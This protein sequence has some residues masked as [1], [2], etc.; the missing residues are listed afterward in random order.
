MQWTD[1]VTPLEALMLTEYVSAMCGNDNFGTT[2]WKSARK[3]L[4]NHSKTCGAYSWEYNVVV[5]PRVCRSSTRCLAQVL[6]K[7]GGPL[8]AVFEECEN[9][10]DGLQAENQPMSSCPCIGRTYPTC[11]SERLLTSS[12]LRTALPPLYPETH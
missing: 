7:A 9:R 11:I 3:C 4:H 1:R 12:S 5:L 6:S 10:H 2:V 8:D